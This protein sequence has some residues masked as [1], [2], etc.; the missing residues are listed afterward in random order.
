MINCPDCGKIVHGALKYRPYCGIKLDPNGVA[1]KL[2]KL[3][4]KV[5]AGMYVHQK[6]QDK[7]RQIGK[8]LVPNKERAKYV[9]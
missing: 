2:S 9:C 7:L 3:F 8:E 5:E 1:I 4:G 6:A